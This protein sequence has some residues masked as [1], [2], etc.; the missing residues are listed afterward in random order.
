M[1]MKYCIV[2]PRFTENYEQSYQFPI[3]IA[4]VSASLKKSGRD[5]LSY[6]LNYKHGAVKELVKKLVLE[7][8]IDVLATGGITGQYWSLKEILEA[9]REVKPNIILWIGGGI[10]TS[11]PIPGMEALEVADY[12]MIGEGEITICE[13]ADV[14]E[15]KRDAHTV[16]GLIFKENDKW[17]ITNP[18]AEITDLDSVPF[19]D[20]EGFDF[21]ELLSKRSTKWFGYGSD[22]FCSMSLGRSCP[23][24]C[25]FC[26]HPSGTK[27]R[28]RSLENFFQ[29]VDY[30]IEKYKIN[31]IFISDELFLPKFEEAKQ[32]CAEVVRRG[33]SF[34]VYHRVDMVNRE[35]LELLRDSGCKQILFGLESADNRILK[36]MCKHITI[37][38]IE[39]ALELCKEIGIEAAGAFI[40]GDEEETTETARNTINWWKAHPDYNITTDLIIMYP[41]SVLYQNA[42][43]KG[44]IKDEV[45]FIKA[46]CPYTNAS[47]L[48]EQEYKDLALEISMLSH[49]RNSINAGQIKYRGSGTADYVA[50]CPNCRT[51]NKIKSWKVF[52]TWR[53]PICEKCGQHIHVKLSD[54]DKELAENNFKLLKNRNVAIWPMIS[55]VENMRRSVP[56]I[57]GDNVYFVD[58][59]AVKQ[60]AC[61]YNKVVHSSSIIAEKEV[62]TVFLTARGI[63]EVAIVDELKKFSTVKHIFFAEDLLDPD[64]YKRI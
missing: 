49:E 5:V 38:Q 1:K 14:I 43:K 20:Y 36:S 54:A 55:V 47:K 44:I 57:M 40:F 23:F 28:R 46:G 37:E 52:D 15:G 4:Y 7:N 35:I 6:N 56:S 45:A 26:F 17:T 16:D 30:L 9:A 13:L 18:R 22:N 64:F 32:F 24:N 41:G 51:V 58:S 61:H 12:G 25:T 29:E 62:D 63:A 11:A 8:D 39:K 33:I 19:P 42:L 27:Y 48:T 21:E 34:G 3:G 50:E 53:S 2:M 31:S 10:I 60:G 59:A